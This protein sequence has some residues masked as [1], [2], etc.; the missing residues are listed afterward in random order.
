[1][2]SRSFSSSLSTATVEKGERSGDL[3]SGVDSGGSP[4][5]RRHLRRRRGRGAGE[6]TAGCAYYLDRSRS[7]VGL[8]GH[9]DGV[10]LGLLFLGGGG[11]CVCCCLE[12]FVAGE[13]VLRLP[14]G[15][16]SARRRRR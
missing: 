16:P 1:M 2:V 6:S 4:P 12:D 9:G 10:A 11:A 15:L 5:L 3:V 8:V 7:R 13:D 14:V